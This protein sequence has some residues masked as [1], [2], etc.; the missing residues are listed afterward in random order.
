MERIKEFLLTSMGR[1]GFVL[2]YL[3]CTLLC[4][5]PVLMLNLPLPV[6]IILGLIVQFFLINIPLA[7]EILYVIGFFGAIAGSQDFIATLY[8]IVFAIIIGSFIIRLIR[9]YK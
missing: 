4:I 9:I 8:Y 7:L 1:F 2:F 3:I 6:A 5:F